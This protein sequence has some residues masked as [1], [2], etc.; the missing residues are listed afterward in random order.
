MPYLDPRRHALREI[1]HYQRSTGLLIRKLSFQCLEAAEA[2]LTG[3]FV[4][5]NLSA[6]HGKRVKVIARDLTLARRIRGDRL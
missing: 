2:Y 4:D 5:T 6:A 1:R 3:L